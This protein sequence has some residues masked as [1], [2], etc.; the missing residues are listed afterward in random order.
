MGAH[1]RNASDLPVIDVRVR[2]YYIAERSPGGEWEPVLRGSPPERIRVVPPQSDRFFPIPE[3]VMSMM[4]QVSDDI[5]AAG[6]W[7]TDA[8][9]NQWE[10]DPRG[11]LV[12]RT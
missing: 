11:A 7:F 8:A 5:Y 2:F 6:V 12:A 4:D 9:G 1:I 10:R 3:Q